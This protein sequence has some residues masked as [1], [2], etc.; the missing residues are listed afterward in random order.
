[1]YIVIFHCKFLVTFLLNVYYQ[2]VIDHVLYISIFKNIDS[3]PN[4]SPIYYI[5]YTY[6]TLNFL[7]KKFVFKQYIWIT[8]FPSPNS[9]KVLPTSL[10]P[11]P[12]FI[13]L[14]KQQMKHTQKKRKT[15]LQNHNIQAKDQLD[16]KK[17]KPSKATW[18][19]SL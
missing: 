8:H 9:S 14:C 3:N 15:T 1:M 4:L 2:I 10:I 13:S 16:K 17:K 5:I 11:C 7:L 19:K 18:D 12:F 6:N